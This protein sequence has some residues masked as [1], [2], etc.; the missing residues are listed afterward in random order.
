MSGRILRISFLLTILFAAAGPCP[1]QESDLGTKTAESAS[2][3]PD[4]GDILEIINKATTPQTDGEKVE[5]AAPVKLV[6]VFALLA[7]IPSL[8]AMTTSFTRIVIVLSFARRAISTQSIPPTIAIVGLAMFLTLFT[9]APTFYRINSEAI[10]PYIAD[11]MNFSEVSS[12]TSG[13]MKE[14]M[15]RQTRETDLSLFIRMAKIERPRQITDVP[16][17]IVVPS[18][19]VSEFRTAFEMGCLLF[20]P[21]LL[22]D[23]VVASILLSAG[24]MMLPPVMISLPF[25]L[26]LFI[27]VDGWGILAHS[28]SLSFR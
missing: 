5:W 10:Q 28:L 20:I 7:I 14:F 27:L 19:I 2:T 22:L 12:L 25:K 8:L 17:H 26:I 6:V 1:A 24:M 13:I 11:K 23:L 3:M 21:F 4:V 9:M 16:F 15:I 18:F